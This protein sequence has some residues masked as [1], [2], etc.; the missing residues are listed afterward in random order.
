MAAPRPMRI[1]GQTPRRPGIAKTAPRSDLPPGRGRA[2]DE[3]PRVLLLL[4]TTTYKARDFLDAAA[5]LGV[6][7]VVGS[8]QP[9]V[10]ESIAPGRTLTLPLHDP[11][12]STHVIEEFARFRPLQAIVPT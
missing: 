9:Q 7:A 4:P 3:A 11:R 10:L 1:L 6:E 2:L 5:E 8:D 12:A